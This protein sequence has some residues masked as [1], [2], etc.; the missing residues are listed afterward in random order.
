MNLSVTDILI[1]QNP[2][3]T[4]V[5]SSKI[6]TVKQFNSRL[7]RNK[8]HLV[9]H[10]GY[11]DAYNNPE[12]VYA[13]IVSIVDS[14]PEDSYHLVYSDVVKDATDKSL[15]I[16]EL[17]LS[18]VKIKQQKKSTQIVLLMPWSSLQKMDDA[19]IRFLTSEM[20]DILIPVN[21]DISSED[22]LLE[23]VDNIKVMPQPKVGF[24]AI[25][26]GRD[27]LPLN[28]A[29][30][31]IMDTAASY[32]TISPDIY[33]KEG[34]SGVI[35]SIFMMLANSYF[36]PSSKK[37]LYN[38]HLQM[39]YNG[40]EDSERPTKVMNFIPAATFLASKI[41]TLEKLFGSFTNFE[42]SIH[43]EYPAAYTL[44]SSDENV[45]TL[46]IK[47]KT[48]TTSSPAYKLRMKKLAEGKAHSRNYAVV[49]TEDYTAHFFRND[50]TSQLVVLISYPMYKANDMFTKWA[51]AVPDSS[52][53]P[54]VLYVNNI[55][56]PVFFTQTHT[57]D[58]S[59]IGFYN[60][61]DL[62][63]SKDPASLSDGDE[64]DIMSRLMDD[65]SIS[66]VEY[67]DTEPLFIRLVENTG[68]TSIST[69]IEEPSFD[70]NETDCMYLDDKNEKDSEDN[71]A[72]KQEIIDTRNILAEAMQ[73][74]LE[75]EEKEDKLKAEGNKS[76][77]QSTSLD[78]KKEE[79]SLNLS[80]SSLDLNLSISNDTKR[81]GG[82]KTTKAK[83][84]DS[85]QTVSNS[86][87][88]SEEMNRKTRYLRYL[89]EIEDMLLEEADEEDLSDSEEE[90]DQN[91]DQSGKKDSSKSYTQRIS[92]TFILSVLY[93]KSISQ[94]VL[95][96]FVDAEL[97]SALAS[98]SLKKLL[99]LIAYP[100]KLHAPYYSGNVSFSDIDT[101]TDH[102]ASSRRY[103][104]QEA[105]SSSEAATKS[106]EKVK[107]AKTKSKQNIL[108]MFK[109]CSDYFTKEN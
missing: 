103:W 33:V 83:A 99:E 87:L 109:E 3:R 62:N 41:E 45:D 44:L 69:F 82:Y 101:Y 30:S 106:L 59:T 81:S 19:D 6:L 55:A 98:A 34:S 21:D 48:I 92:Y 63:D 58:E 13:N 76:K 64:E 57:L 89:Q 1:A 85:I 100:T 18:L 52:V 12:L 74:V 47:E 35:G 75:E 54:F 86:A 40:T 36:S 71:T 2:Q 104:M 20:C 38:L 77:S 22:W 4:A 53:P 42:M 37:R 66:M 8:R 105:I 70:K 17:F 32:S 88:I 7:E 93:N 31:D 102:L 16:N 46:G 72:L 67:T 79:L 65:K 14:S 9:A 84:S 80:D 68:G 95:Y 24:P 26:T 91:I 29:F 60:V 94:N 56:F 107:E 90:E 10:L 43:N 97:Y 28:I 15:S 51:L 108:N 73:K 96:S 23:A 50:A 61:I 11:N 27:L 49:K 25:I 39:N 78:S 5:K